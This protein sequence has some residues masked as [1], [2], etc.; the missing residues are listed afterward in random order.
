MALNRQ[1]NLELCRLA[2]ILLVILVHTTAKSVGQEAS[3]GVLLLEGFSI[4]GVNVFVLLTGY[5]SVTPKKSSI[6]NL[7]F[8]CFFWMWISILCNYCNGE[9]V[10]IK[11]FFFISSSNWFI[12]SYI[13]LLM[14]AP[15]LNLFCNTVSKKVLWGGVLLLLSLEV[16]FEWIPPRAE[17][18]A[19]RGYSTLSFMVLYLLARA[20]RLYG[21]PQWFK[22]YCLLIYIACSIILGTIPHIM[23]SIGKPDPIGLWFAYI[24]PI[25]VVSSVAFLTFFERMSFESSFVNY[26]AKSTLAVLFGQSAIW[27]LYIRQF[28]YLY[29]NYNGIKIIVFW[30]IAVLSVFCFS[31]VIDQIRLFLY[32]PLMR[33]VNRFI[34]NDYIFDFQAHNGGK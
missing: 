6:I 10:G 22:K 12:P 33:V 19:L 27:S 25:V 4:I 31:I 13:Y 3:F 34:K 2:S 32:K 11:S 20:I 7:A 24:N 9:V 17:I 29:N 28:K 5:F 23:V 26:I 1:S 16:W 14:F 8:I 18:G 30:G 21:L 15:F